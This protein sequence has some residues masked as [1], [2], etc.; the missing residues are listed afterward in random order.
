MSLW[1]AAIAAFDFVADNS[2]SI[3]Q[4]GTTIAGQVISANA[5]EDAARRVAEATDRRTAAIQAGTQTRP[6][7]TRIS[8]AVQNPV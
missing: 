5:N 2:D 4:A 1:D 7:A 3:V 6:H 8:S